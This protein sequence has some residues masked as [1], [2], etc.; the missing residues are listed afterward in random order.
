MSQHQLSVERKQIKEARFFTVQGDG[1][2]SLAR[3]DFEIIYIR[4][5]DNEDGKPVYRYLSLENFSSDLSARGNFVKVLGAL[6]QLTPLPE[7]GSL[8]KNCNRQLRNS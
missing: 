7:N 6:A 4:Y 1:S 8:K 2:M 5:F 3:R